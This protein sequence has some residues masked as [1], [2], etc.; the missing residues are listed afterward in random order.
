MVLPW[1][2]VRGQA[3]KTEDNRLMMGGRKRA[4]RGDH[5]EGD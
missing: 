3:A 2:I 1:V 5:E 4:V